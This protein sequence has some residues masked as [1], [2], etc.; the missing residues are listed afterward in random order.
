[1]GEKKCKKQDGNAIIMLILVILVILVMTVV[2]VTIVMVIM[3]IMVKLALTM[4]AEFML[5]FFRNRSLGEKEV[6]V[7][8]HHFSISE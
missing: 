8:L 2:T 3:G 1:M 7:R 5:G 4:S 6:A